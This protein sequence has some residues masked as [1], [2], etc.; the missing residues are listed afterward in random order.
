MYKIL[1]IACCIVCAVILAAVIFIFAY[2]GW[3][4][5]FAALLAAAV[6]F[7]LTVLFKNLQEREENKNAPPAHG[8]FITGAVKKNDKEDDAQ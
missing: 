8:D 3:A 7:G 6:F 4:W 2:L 5:G 1:R